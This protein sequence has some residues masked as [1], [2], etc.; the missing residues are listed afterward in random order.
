[1]NK[2]QRLLKLKNRSVIGVLSGTSVDALDVVHVNINGSGRSSDLQV[3]NYQ[4]FEIPLD[5]REMVLKASAVGSGRVDDIC[6]LNV[7][8]GHFIA[9]CIMKYLETNGL[10]KSDIDLIGSHGQT[11]HH[12]PEFKSTSGYRY[13]STLQIGDPSVIANTT[14]IITVGDF[15]VADV[16]VSGS[17]APLVP[18]LDYIMFSV[19]DISRILINIGGIANLT[20]LRAS[21]EEND[22]IAF[23]TGPGN[24]LIDGFSKLYFNKKYDEDAVISKSGSVNSALLE[25]LKGIDNYYKSKPPKSTGREHYGEEIFRAV[26]NFDSG[27]SKKD[28]L[29]TVTEFT[30]F[31]IAHN[32]SSYLPALNTGD[33]II[34]SG[35]GARNPLLFRRIKEE[36]LIAKVLTVNDN[37]IT[38]ENKEAILF[39]VL[40]NEAISGNPCNIM[41]VTGAEKNVI[42]GKICLVEN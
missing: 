31:T 27:I 10:S 25:Y 21:G 15:R 22:I 19:T 23:D 36:F 33:E 28:V 13:R 35:G 26:Q 42:L 37:G 38:A 1:M 29:R 17:G 7:L 9:D 2:L 34:L 24:M 30:V 41:S 16:A 14:G 40:A 11:I 3:N 39:A 8:L 12:L 6:A 20:Y 5:I 4:E 32:I 18:Y